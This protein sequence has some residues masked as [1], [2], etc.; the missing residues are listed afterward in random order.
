MIVSQKGCPKCD[1]SVYVGEEILEDKSYDV[2]CIVCGSRDFPTEIGLLAN[3]LQ[4]IK[5]K[6]ALWTGRLPGQ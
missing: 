3:T 1:G 5:R 4:K 2:F 6:Y